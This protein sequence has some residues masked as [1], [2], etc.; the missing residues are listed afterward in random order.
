MSFNLLSLGIQAAQ[1]NKT[2][3]SVVGQNISNVNTPGYN[4]QVANLSTLPGQ[5][6]VEVDKISRITDDFL[7]RQLWADT[8]S[9][10]RSDI[11]SDLASE[12]D[13]LLASNSTSISTAMDQYFNALQNAVDDPTSL[14]NRE[15]FV[16]ESEALARRFNDLNTV[17]V[18]QNE[19]INENLE[20]YSAQ[21]T[22]L[23]ADIAD[24]NNKIRLE[25]VA[26]KPANELRDQRDRLV[27]QLSE[28]IDV[29][30]VAQD[31]DEFAVFVANG[32]PLVVGITA[33]QMRP[34]QGNP[35]PTQDGIALVIA[36][37]EVTITNSMQGGKIGGVL[38]YRN[39][40]LVPAMNEIGR[41]AIAFAETMNEQHQKGMDLDGKLGGLL[42]NDVNS[43]I[44]MTNRIRTNEFNAGALAASYVKITDVNDLKA[45]D[46]EI[47][48]GSSGDLT[49]WRLSDNKRLTLDDF[50]AVPASATNSAVPEQPLTEPNT[51]FANWDA[52]VVH[53]SFDGISIELNA[54]GRF[55]EGDRYLIQPTRNG[56]AEIGT[57]VN[58]GRQLA[59]ASPVRVSTSPDNTGT[60]RVEVTV[61]NINAPTFQAAAG[62]MSPP[63]E[64]VFNAGSP[65]TF[66]VYD[67]SVPDAPVPLTIT[68]VGT[69]ANQ[70]YTPGQAITLDG[71]EI[72]ISNQPSVGDRFSFGYNTDGVSDNRNALAM[73]NLQLADT[74]E[75]GS[76][77]DIY[78]RLIERVGTDTS[79]ASI[80]R[81]ASLSVLTSTQESKAS[82]SG[83]N[84][85]EEAAKLVQFQQ[86]YQA[87]A[88]LISASQTLF[89]ALLNSVRG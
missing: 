6:G 20:S 41:I 80:N 53:L 51:Y 33:N 50:T 42:F 36:G 63:V 81:E 76:Y 8:A 27:E 45:S 25:T 56:A 43:S 65:K 77:Q 85:D 40:V 2:A 84:L 71:Y 58:N 19:K 86:A 87:S 52:G 82:M 4:R 12:L 55:I 31:G 18:R 67:M 16:A 66:T 59:L 46:Y 1:A 32:Q 29:R 38:D 34:V 37:N 62:E 39:D 13:N 26:G 88:Q 10:F 3:L 17:V 15:L 47:S 5:S 30:V 35:D 61:T 70:I 9:Y 64:I 57:V 83:V 28:L 54:V 7:T 75:G 89:D 73:S 21:V 68:G 74:L 14:P 23:G 79:V 22:T 48:I 60:G 78:G 44:A 11:F 49:I 72:V 69:L 24:L